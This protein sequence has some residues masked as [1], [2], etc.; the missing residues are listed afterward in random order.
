MNVLSA[1]AEIISHKK[2]NRQIEYILSL[3]ALEKL[4]GNNAKIIHMY[5]DMMMDIELGVND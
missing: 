4:T 1:F 3:Q 2:R 5:D